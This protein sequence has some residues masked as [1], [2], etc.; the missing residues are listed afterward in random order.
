MNTQM[1][2]LYKGE[3]ASSICSLGSLDRINS[4]VD[5]TTDIGDIDEPRPTFTIGDEKTEQGLASF[6]IIY[7]KAVIVLFFIV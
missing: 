6:L 3:A 5:I 7:L 4:Q 1:S 2:S